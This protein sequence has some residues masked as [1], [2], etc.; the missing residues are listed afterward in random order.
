MRS[1]GVFVAA[2]LVALLLEVSFFPYLPGSPRPHLPLVL[3]CSAGLVF[4]PQQGVRV[5]LLA[6]LLVDGWI[7]RLVGSAALIHAGA[8]WLAGHL[9]RGLYRDVPGL[10]PVTAAVATFT[11]DTLRGLLAG[12]VAEPAVGSVAMTGGWPRVLLPDAAAAAIVAPLVFRFVLW[13]ERRE[14]AARNYGTDMGAGP[15]RL[16]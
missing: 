15:V 1:P 11:A 14:R 5:G 16:E 13:V 6:G 12:L 2:A 10:A 3:A 4:G 7:G 9:G 8:A